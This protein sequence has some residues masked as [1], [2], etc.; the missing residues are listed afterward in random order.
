[1]FL[2]VARLGR[3]P[4]ELPWLVDAPAWA[5][6]AWP[7]SSSAARRPLICGG[8]RS[9]SGSE[10]AALRKF[11]VRDSYTTVLLDGSGAEVGRVSG[12]GAGLAALI[13]KAH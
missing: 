12:D 4:G 7:R 11:G 9:P 3:S 13:A 2:R 6:S 5:H 1:M 8:S 10:P